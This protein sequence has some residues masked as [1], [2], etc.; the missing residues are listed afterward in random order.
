MF[1]NNKSYY[2]IIFNDIF[3][4]LG[5]MNDMV[6]SLDGRKLIRKIYHTVIRIMC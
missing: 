3:G 6:W 1:Q 2:F 4:T 5:F